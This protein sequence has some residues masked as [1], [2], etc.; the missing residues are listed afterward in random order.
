[1]LGAKSFV[2]FLMLDPKSPF[3]PK[4]LSVMWFVP[5][6]IGNGHIGNQRVT[7]DWTH[8]PWIWFGND[9]QGTPKVCLFRKFAVLN[10]LY[11][12]GMIWQVKCPM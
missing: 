7:K 12:I 2:A 5:I 3:K 10:Q 11:G 9:D 8:K 6:A 4:R 1:M